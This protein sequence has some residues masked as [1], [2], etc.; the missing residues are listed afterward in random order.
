MCES[1]QQ[2]TSTVVLANRNAYQYCALTM[3]VFA[4]KCMS[5]K[6]YSNGV[7]LCVSVCT[8]VLLH[9]LPSIDSKGSWSA[10]VL[11]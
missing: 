10:T 8:V 3:G 2:A 7:I 5:C 9:H 11:A 6:D 1:V 4:C